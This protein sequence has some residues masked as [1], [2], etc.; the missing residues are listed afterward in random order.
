VGESKVEKSNLRVMHKRDVQ[1]WKGFRQGEYIGEIRHDRSVSP[2]VFHYL[3][4]REGSNEIVVW[5]QERA[6]QEARRALEE[7]LAQLAA[8]DQRRA[9]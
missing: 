4:T 3:V 9:L 5:A 6:P 7:T 1:Q 2:P 8:G